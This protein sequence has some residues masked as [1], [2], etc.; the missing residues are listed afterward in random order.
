MQWF[1]THAH[2]DDEQFHG[3]LDGVLDRAGRAG[4]TRVL[5]VGTTAASSDACVQIARRF[6]QVYAA[7]GIQ[8]NDGAAASA[9]DWERVVALSRDERVR[10]I[11]ETGLDAHW[12]FTPWAVQRE[13]FERHVHLAQAT[14]LPLVIHMRDC[15]GPLV[16]ML[17]EARARGPLSGVMHAFTGTLETAR[18]CLRLGLYISFAGM[19]T[20]RN[21]RAL[22]E[23]ASEIPDDRIV[24]ETDAP[25]LSPHP[26]RG[27]RPNEPAL[28]VHTARCIAETRGVSLEQLAQ[29]TTLNAREL[30]A[31]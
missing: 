30:L 31:V 20:F 23:V 11:G 27:Q 29:R 3:A 10:A 7:V 22:R 12:D 25:Y 21:A 24:L 5:T 18:S 17:E 16:A 9:T 1:D 15:E 13:L 8:P 2:L 19:V 14:G 4:V 26:H 6:E 28:L